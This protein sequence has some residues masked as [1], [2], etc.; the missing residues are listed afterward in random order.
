[1]L[2][3]SFAL[4]FPQLKPAFTRFTSLPKVFEYAF[5]IVAFVNSLTLSTAS[6]TFLAAFL[7]G[8]VTHRV[9]TSKIFTG[10]VIN[11][12]ADL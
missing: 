1:M 4:S 3:F 10:K 11:D 9:A 8:L 2:T 6:L 7:N 5:L 12:F